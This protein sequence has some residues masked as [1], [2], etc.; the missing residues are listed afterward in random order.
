MIVG[1]QQM[2]SDSQTGRWTTKDPIRFDG[3]DLNIYRYVN[4]DPVNLID[5]EGL[6]NYGAFLFDFFRGVSGTS[7]G[8]VLTGNF[9][10][11]GLNS[12][13]DASHSAW[14]AEQRRMQA[15]RDAGSDPSIQPPSRTLNDLIDPNAS[16]R[17]QYRC[18]R[19]R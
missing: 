19:L 7:T 12:N 3:D 14:L 4:N 6:F 16:L 9:G 15:L 17:P 18:G 13:A 2:L 1:S 10:G 11:S 8:S 5:P